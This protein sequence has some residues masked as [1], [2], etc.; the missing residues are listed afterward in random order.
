MCGDILYALSFQ[1]ISDRVNQE[2]KGR[3][4]KTGGPT[5]EKSKGTECSGDGPEG[6]CRV[7]VGNQA[8]SAAAPT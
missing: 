3:S 5:G 4:T 7:I 2:R 6:R 1:P 8:P